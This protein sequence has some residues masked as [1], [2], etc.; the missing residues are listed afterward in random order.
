MKAS[1][2]VPVESTEVP[3]QE[4]GVGV[5][6]V[7]AVGHSMSQCHFNLLSHLLA[8]DIPSVHLAIENF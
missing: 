8:F 5:G 4:D 6:F 7:F 2:D 3:E 1:F